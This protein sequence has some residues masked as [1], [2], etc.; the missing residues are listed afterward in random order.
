MS[1]LIRGELT[2]LVATRLHRWGI[3][4]ALLCGGGLTGL[5]ALIGPENATPP[6]PAIDTPDGA[7]MVVGV[8][9]VLLFVPALIGTIAITGEYRH[10]TIAATFLAEPRR[11]RVLGAKLVVFSAFGLAYGLIASLASAAALCLSALI[12]GVDL[13]LPASQLAGLLAQLS[14][15]AAV[16]MVLGVGIG[17]IARHQ[18]VAVGIVVGYFYFLEY[19]LLIIPGIN[20]IYPFLPGGA[21]AGL[22]SFTFVTDAIAVQGASDGPTLLPAPAGA[23]VLLGYALIAAGFATLA[24]LRRDLT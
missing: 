18:L 19:V 22:T 17:A 24:P 23:L 14:V 16:Y 1:H 21:T 10:R 2:R 15:A 5:L 4:A 12:R 20:T 6:M 13:G 9:G 7:G 8:T 11:G 3:L